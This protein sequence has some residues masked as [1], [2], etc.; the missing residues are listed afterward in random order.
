MPVRRFL[1]AALT[2]F[3]TQRAITLR[4]S[5]APASESIGD[6]ETKQV[7]IERDCAFKSPTLK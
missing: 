7:R 4:A 5:R 3:P 1:N 6:F 2:G